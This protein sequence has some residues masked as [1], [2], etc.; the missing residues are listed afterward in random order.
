M[1]DAPL[2]LLILGTVRTGQQAIVASLQK[3]FDVEVV[4]RVDQALDALR[5]GAYNAVL[6]DVG[7]FLPLERELVGEKAALVLN[8]IGE[9]VI[10]VDADGRCAWSNKRMRSFA[11]EVIEKVKQICLQARQIFCQQVETGTW[12]AVMLTKGSLFIQALHLPT[13]EQ[14]KASV[15]G[16]MA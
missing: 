15:E 8:T 16:G 7:D 9:G 1:A 11:P 2:R 6:T 13:L 3:L 5:H 12:T 14:A 4:E 10:I